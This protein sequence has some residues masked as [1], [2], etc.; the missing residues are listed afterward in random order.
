[1]FLIRVADAQLSAH[2]NIFNFDMAAP[3]TS[4]IQQIN[5]AQDPQTGADQDC[6][7]W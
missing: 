4:F 1:M 6:V 2:T 7:P 3:Y 5:D